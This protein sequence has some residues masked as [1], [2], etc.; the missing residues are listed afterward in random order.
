M[1]NT[2]YTIEDLLEILAGLK[3]SAKFQI[4]PSDSTIMNS[5]ARQVFK[6]TALTDRQHALMKEKL[7]NYRDQFTSLEYDFDSAIEKLRNPLRQIDRSKYI[8]IVTT[9]EVYGENT[10]Y[11]SSKENLKWI[12]I[13]FP[14]SKKDIV[15]VESVAFKNRKTYYHPKGSHEHFFVLN[16]LNVY[17]VLKEFEN[18]EFKIDEELKT[19]YNECCSIMDS[20]KSYVPYYQDGKFVNL[21]QTQ[22]DYISLKNLNQT[23]IIDRKSLLGYEVYSDLQSSDDVL[24]LV[25]QR[26]EADVCIKPSLYNISDIVKTVVELDRYPLLVV[27]EE[28]KAQDQIIDIFD[29][30]KYVVSPEQQCVLFRQD[31]K[32]EFNHF[33]REKKLNNWLDKNTKIVYIS[34]TNLPKLLIK[35]NFN[36]IAALL[37]DNTLNT[38]VHSYIKNSCDLILNYAEVLSPYRN[39]Y[40]Y[41]KYL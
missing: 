39:R 31:G 2:A 13:R 10:P 38:F 4:N 32:T 19:I 33:V 41:G 6:G 8:K 9:A 40:S 7:Q 14:F 23:Q 18:K 30:F 22:K 20:T 25:L 28:L 26:K 3:Q 17:N 15:K 21:N 11:E 1:K 35:E 5:V 12:K 34:N 36:P 29:N 27:L 24:S 16:E 37:F